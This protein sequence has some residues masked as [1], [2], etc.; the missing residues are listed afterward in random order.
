M[1]FSFRAALLL[2]LVAVAAGPAWAQA[3]T[4][5]PTPSATPT[6]TPAATPA[7]KWYDEIAVNGFVSVAYSYNTNRPDSRTNQYR[8]FDY[9]DNTFRLDVAELTIQRA[10]SK[11]GEVGFRVDAEAGATIPPV[12][13]SYGLFQ[14]ENFDLK[15]AFVSY[16]APV[17]SGL[18]ID[19][20]KYLTHFNYE[21]IESWDTPNDNATH[22]FTFGYALPY[23]HTGLRASYTFNEQLAAMVMLANGWDNVKDNNSA[24]TVGAQLT[25]TPVKSV[26][27]AANF[28]TGPERTDVNSDPRTVWELVAQWKLSD[29]TVFGLDLLYGRERGAVVQGQ[30][31]T[32]TGIVAY[33]RLGVSGLFAVCLRGEYFDDAEG[34]RTGV[35]QKLKEVTVTPELRVSSHFIFRSD[36]RVDWSDK[37]VFEKKGGETSKTQPTVALNAIYMF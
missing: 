32:W 18:K 8:V 13:A 21:Y 3:P 22:S 37:P 36:L 26:S 30:L 12:S 25:W 28:C 23:A 2:T 34:A 31:A 5:S 16:V 7:P 20:G 9:Q 1:R 10:T 15:Q 33:A 11:R 24:K 17:G 6:P 4:L 19:A 29:L 14:G 35:A 27:V